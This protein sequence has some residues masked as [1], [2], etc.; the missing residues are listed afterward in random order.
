MGAIR[1]LCCGNDER[2]HEGLQP[3]ASGD[4]VANP[5][6]STDRFNTVILNEPEH[7]ASPINAVIR[8]YFPTELPGHSCRRWTMEFLVVAGLILPLLGPLLGLTIVN[9]LFNYYIAKATVL[10]PDTDCLGGNAV[11]EAHSTF[12]YYFWNLTNYDEVSIENFY[13]QQQ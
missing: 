1:T 7:P 3:G 6:S 10:T 8:T 11:C 2:Q 5:A 9:P 4:T 13:C 12:E